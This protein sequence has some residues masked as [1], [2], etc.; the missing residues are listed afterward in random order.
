M[1]R[2]A[3]VLVLSMWVTGALSAGERPAGTMRVVALPA[4]GA[5]ELGERMA[6]LDA[7]IAVQPARRG[8]LIA[9][10]H[11]IM[12]LREV[13]LA[14]T[15]R[16]Q[17]RCVAAVA[18]I[19]QPGV[20][21]GVYVVAAQLADGTGTVSPADVMALASLVSALPGAVVIAGDLAPM[22]QQPLADLFE[23]TT[24]ASARHV[25]TTAD[26]PACAAFVQPGAHGTVSVADLRLHPIVPVLPIR[27]ASIESN[28]V[29]N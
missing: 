12:D 17:D 15:E 25:F 1:M 2:I 8:S 9:S 6:N 27:R 26:L 11:R 7:D 10:R 29:A 21:G 3:A 5:E 16:P 20:P 18:H 19:A 14:P 23:S 13:E 24:A 4:A 22:V 28:V